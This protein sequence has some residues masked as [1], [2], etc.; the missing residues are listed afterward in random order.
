MA[1]Q[2][3]D[4]IVDIIV[5]Q[6]NPSRVLLF[7][8]RARGTDAA[9]SDYDLCIILQALSGRRLLLLREIRTALR[10]YGKYDMDIIVLT[11][12]EF[13]EKA[14]LAPTLEYAIKREGVVLYDQ[15]RHSA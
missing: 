5:R 13:S 1:N 6:F 3:I 2:E 9:E 7:G 10:E 15:R 14:S 8:S 11:E 4:N 12:K